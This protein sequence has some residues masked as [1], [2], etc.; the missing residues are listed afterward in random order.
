MTRIVPA[1]IARH[2]IELFREEI[3]DL[4][5][6][7]VAP[8]GAEDDYVS[9]FDQTDLVYRTQARGGRGN[10]KAET[11]KRTPSSRRPAVR[12]TLALDADFRSLPG[13]G[14]GCVCATH[15]RYLHRQAESLPDLRGL[16]G[17]RAPHQGQHRESAQ[18]RA[19]TLGANY[20]RGRGFCQGSGAGHPGL[21]SGHDR[22]GAGFPGRTA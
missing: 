20:R 14:T 19:E 15:P 21:P 12:D 2:N 1:L 8:L 4:A 22:S 11:E 17:S 13:P 6:T 9:H 7:L 18:S 5:F 16:Q 10:G 3:D